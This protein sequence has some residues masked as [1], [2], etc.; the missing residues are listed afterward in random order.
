MKAGRQGRERNIESKI[1]GR[2]GDELR[3]KKKGRD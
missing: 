1:R 3:K 2:K